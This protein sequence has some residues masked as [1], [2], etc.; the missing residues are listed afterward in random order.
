MSPD[1]LLSQLGIRYDGN[2]LQGSAA[3][4]VANLIKLTAAYDAGEYYTPDFQTAPLSG[5]SFDPANVLKRSALSAAYNDVLSAEGAI[6]DAERTEFLELHLGAILDAIE[7]GVPVHGY[8]YWSLMDN[9]EWAWGYDKRFGIVRVDYETQVRTP[10]DS[11]IAY[12]RII[13]GRSL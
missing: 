12:T 8:F 5:A 7:L 4:I 10:K 1:V 6:H 11:A 3:Q 2:G 9:F 13:T